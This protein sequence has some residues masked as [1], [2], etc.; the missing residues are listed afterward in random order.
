MKSRIIALAVVLLIFSGCA[1]F[2]YQPN[3]PDNP[4]ACYYP[5]AEFRG[6]EGPYCSPTPQR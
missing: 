5:Y 3:T 1:G 2:K 4:D 6:Y